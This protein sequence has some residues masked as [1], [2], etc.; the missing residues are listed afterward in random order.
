MKF[1]KS[2]DVVCTTFNHERYIG[3]TI[4][5]ILNQDVDADVRIIIH[6]DASTDL[7]KKIISSYYNRYPKKIHPIYQTENQYSKGIKIIDDII[8]PVVTGDYVAYCEGD[9]YWSDSEKLKL[10]MNVLEHHPGCHMCVHKVRMIKEDGS[11][12]TKTYPDEN[13]SSGYV[14]VSEVIGG[15]YPYQ[16]SSYFFRG[17]EFRKFLNQKTKFRNLSP[18]GDVTCLLYFSA[19]GG[20]FYINRE[21]SCYRRGVP[22]SVTMSWNQGA[23]N[24]RN[25][26]D[27][28][29]RIYRLY[30]SYIEYDVF[31]FG[32]YHDL[33]MK[34]IVLYY[35]KLVILSKK[36]VCV[37]SRPR[38][39]DILRYGGVSRTLFFIFSRCFHGIAKKIFKYREFCITR[40]EINSWK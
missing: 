6:D 37:K 15:G 11:V 28:I 9:D 16:T 29:N 7:T 36:Y 38:L 32:K 17:S 24:D 40:N 23:A 4:E 35:V 13:N 8:L 25:E 26:H 21:M 14:N 3:K 39:I 1:R 20:I 22:T 34:S 30:L 5:G 31:T 12:T 2:I 27:F 19:F 33:C 18:A 10:Q